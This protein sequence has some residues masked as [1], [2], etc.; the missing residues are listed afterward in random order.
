[1]LADEANRVEASAIGAAK[2]QC[3]IVLLPATKVTEAPDF[4]PL[5]DM[6]EDP[7]E[8]ALSQ[9]LLDMQPAASPYVIVDQRKKAEEVP[10]V[11]PPKGSLD[12][13]DKEAEDSTD[14]KNGWDEVST[15]AKKRRNAKRTKK[16]N[17]AA[18]Q[19]KQ[20]L[21]QADTKMGKAN[22]QVAAACQVSQTQTK[23]QAQKSP[24]GHCPLPCFCAV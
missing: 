7:K 17:K 19:T 8:D 2:K 21:V 24:G 14:T 6:P 1:M 4:L 23:R 3:D 20:N 10:D 16:E 15:T 11:L 18:G 9:S 13:L 12:K 22:N 5:E